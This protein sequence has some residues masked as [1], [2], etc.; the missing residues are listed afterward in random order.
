M[1]NCVLRWLNGRDRITVLEAS[2]GDEDVQLPADLAATT[3]LLTER[4]S[5]RDETNCP[6]A[7]KSWRHKLQLKAR[8]TLKA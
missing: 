2:L 3:S 8:K 6:A 7:G 1:M 4:L 5:E